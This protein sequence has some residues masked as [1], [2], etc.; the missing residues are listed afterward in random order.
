MMLK[1]AERY[2]TPTGDICI[3]YERDIDRLRG[4]ITVD[5]PT[6]HELMRAAG[7]TRVDNL[8]PSQVNER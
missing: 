5:I 4:E 6:F 8:E 7:F 2:V 1:A 3:V